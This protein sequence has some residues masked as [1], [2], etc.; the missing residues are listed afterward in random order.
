M[1]NKANR[2]TQ[3]MNV[4]KTT[5]YNQFDFLSGKNRPILPS[6]LRKITIAMKEMI[7][8]RTKEHAFLGVILVVRKGNTLWIY[9]GQHRF[10]V[11]KELGV[12]ISYQIIEVSEDHTS[13]TLI[14]LN[15]SSTNWQNQQFV[16]HYKTSDNKVLSSNYKWIDKLQKTIKMPVTGKGN[17][18]QQKTIGYNTISLLLTGDANLAKLRKGY[19]ELIPNKKRKEVEKNAAYLKSYYKLGI[20]KSY[21]IRNVVKY[22]INESNYNHTSILSKIKRDIDIVPMSETK[23]QEYLIQT[24]NKI[25][26]NKK[27]A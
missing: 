23:M 22:L 6:N 14:A 27:A 24:Y 3:L 9:D 26:G 1:F 17:K 10:T 2:D 18:I 8:L 13:G 15:T 11:A 21:F 25:C 5:N 7:L 16:D 12:P 20:D 19:T 4:F